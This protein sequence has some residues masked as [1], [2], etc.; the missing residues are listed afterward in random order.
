V[1]GGKARRDGG[2]GLT[3]FQTRITQLL[4]IKYPIIQGAMMWLSRAEMVAA[5][6]NAGGLGIMAALTFATAEELRE[7]IGK[8]KSLTDKPF[9]VNITL[10]PTISPR[11]LEEYINT[12]IEEGVTII[13]TAG[14]NPRQYM[15]Q[16][17]DGG[18]K[19]MHKVASVKAART[20]E[21]IGVDAVTI[22]GFEEG[23][24]PG[25]DD[26]TTMILVPRTVDALDIPV[27]A[28]GGIGDGRGLM[29]ALALGA[30][31]A[32]MGTRFMMSKESPLHPKIKQRLL[33]ATEKDT[34][35][36]MRSIN[37]PERVLTTGFARRILEME[38][39]GTTLEELLPM[40]DGR[41]QKKALD[42]GEVSEAIIPCGQGVGLISDLPTIKEIIDGIIREAG[43]IAKRLS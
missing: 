20:A 36:I 9:A 22:V 27:I 5:V 23:G 15:K 25:M 34:L 16:L 29:A 30:E 40:I 26:V 11:S 6:A 3:M 1:G 7:E 12:A 8:A 4:G 21:R 10:L 37:N 14:R 43:T 2:V 42:K 33:E 24:N 18:V 28:G 19:V 17:R 32:V 13:E 35:M 31:G 38:E 39:K 41:R